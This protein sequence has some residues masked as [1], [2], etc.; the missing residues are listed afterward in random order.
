MPRP[1]VDDTDMTS[2]DFKAL[3]A[4]GIPCKIVTSREEYER[5]RN[6]RPEG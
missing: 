1:E 4:D 6:E 5:R 3:M 2:A